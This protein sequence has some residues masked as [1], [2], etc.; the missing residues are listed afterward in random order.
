MKTIVIAIAA[1]AAATAVPA[2]AAP[3]ATAKPVA[4][5]AEPAKAKAR[6]YCVSEMVTGSRLPIKMCKTRAEWAAEGFDVD[7]PDG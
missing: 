1:L 5:Q 7:Q 4:D 6:K 2:F 3:S